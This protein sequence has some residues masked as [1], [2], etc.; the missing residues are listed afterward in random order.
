MH[1]GYTLIDLEQMLYS[2]CHSFN[3]GGS[4]LENKIESKRIGKECDDMR[5]KVR[6]QG[7]RWL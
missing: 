2:S 3:K 1:L 6:K 4:Q 5:E 7:K